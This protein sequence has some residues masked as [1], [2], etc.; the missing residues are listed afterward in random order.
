MILEHIRDLVEEM[1]H[2]DT[3]WAT[4]WR[5][6]RKIFLYAFLVLFMP[7]GIP[8]TIL[9]VTKK[10]CE[11][12]KASGESSSPGSGDEGEGRPQC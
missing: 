5:V 4:V 2:K 9:L 1:P 10:V 6:V 11:R 12:K 7:G 3:A 8:L